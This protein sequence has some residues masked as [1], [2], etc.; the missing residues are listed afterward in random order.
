MSTDRAATAGDQ[1]QPQRVAGSFRDPLGHVF[2]YQG[3]VFRAVDDRCHQMLCD[4]AAGQQLQRFREAGLVVPTDLVE[5]AVLLEQLK[6][7]EPGFRHFLRHRTIPVLSW[8]YEWTV[9]ML[10]DAARTTLDLQ[11]RL[12]EA[13]YALKDAT[14]YNVQFVGGRPT[15]IDLS[16][17]ERP[18]RPDVWFA[19]GQFSQMFTFP[20]L[21]CRHA[22]WD[23]RS[24]FLANLGG[25]DAARVAA[26]FSPLGRLRPRLLLDVTLPALLSRWARRRQFGPADPPGATTQGSRK[27]GT[28]SVAQTGVAEAETSPPRCLSPFS[29]DT[30]PEAPSQTGTGTVADN[31]VSQGQLVSGDGASPRLRLPA[32]SNSISNPVVLNLKRLRRKISRL[33]AGYRPAGTWTGYQDH[34]SYDEAAQR[35]KSALVEGFLQRTRPPRV[36]DL[37]CN[38]GHYSRLA[39]RL[40]AEVI[41]ADSDHDAVEILYRRLRQTPAP[42]VPMVVDL[43]NPSPGVGYMNQERTAWLER[44]QSDCVLALALLHHLLVVGNLSLAAVRDMFWALSRRDLVLEFVP[45]DDPM[46]RRLLEFRIDLFAD[47]TLDACREVFCQRFDLLREEPIVGTRRTLLF[48][49]KKGM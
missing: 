24:Y 11:M 46:F 17:I 32:L 10:A 34:C 38:T 33:A 31:A 49:R 44:A 7:V 47:L 29:A 40:G 27:M 43:G 26:N 12:M 39:A 3:Q 28:G 35:A 20:L 19:L 25:L 37:G 41:A 4:L 15:F 5:D 45:R 1:A 6:A 18:R 21:L 2:I 42:I 9:S 22:G 14:A 13:G 16:S 30:T 36:L 48:L 8:P 23:L